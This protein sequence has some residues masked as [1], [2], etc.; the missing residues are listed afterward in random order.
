MRIASL[1]QLGTSN[2]NTDNNTTLFSTRMP[3]HFISQQG[4]AKAPSDLDRRVIRSHVMRGKNAGKARPAKRRRAEVHIRHVLPSTAF[5]I[6]RPRRQLFWNDLSLTTFPQELDA[7]STRLM[8]RCWYL[9]TLCIYIK[10]L[11]YIFKSG[12]F[13]ISDSLFPPQFCTK[14]DMV[15]SLWV[16]F[17]LADEACESHKPPSEVPN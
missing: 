7:E 3:L 14:F 16:N 10:E 13:D 17:V 1:I 8:H 4:N 5:L 2:K 15:K 12:F 11:I 9:S 6:R